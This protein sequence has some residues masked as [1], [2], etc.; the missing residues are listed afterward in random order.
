MAAAGGL[1]RETR[2]PDILLQKLTTGGVRVGCSTTQ[3]YG[4]A[5]L[6]VVAPNWTIRGARTSQRGWAGPTSCVK[7]R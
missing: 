2:K 3:H 6:G 1:Q 5:S 7:T 4:D